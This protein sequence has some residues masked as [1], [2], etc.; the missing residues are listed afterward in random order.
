[1][2]DAYDV[3][4]FLPLIARERKRERWVS[5]PSSSYIAVRVRKYYYYGGRGRL[6]AW[7]NWKVDASC[8]GVSFVIVA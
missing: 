2:E 4:T 3:S 7:S 5:K 8:A 1:M 6:R